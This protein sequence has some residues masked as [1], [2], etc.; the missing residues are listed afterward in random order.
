MPLYKALTRSHQE[1]FSQDSS[2]VN[3]MRE[4]YF[5][6]HHPNFNHENTL[7]FMEVFWCMIKTAD[8]FGSVIFEITEAWSGQDEL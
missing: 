5:W 4:E 8:R 1:V 2:L 6:S 7:D 3:G